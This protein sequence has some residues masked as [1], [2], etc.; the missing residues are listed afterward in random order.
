MSQ[1]VLQIWHKLSQ[2]G[3]KILGRL[4]CLSV[5]VSLFVMHFPM[6]YFLAFKFIYLA[7]LSIAFPA[8]HLP[9]CD[10]MS[11]TSIGVFAIKICSILFYLSH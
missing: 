10:N 7:R 8:V 3:R 1:R 4:S 2:S 6:S 11:L 5:F 9:A